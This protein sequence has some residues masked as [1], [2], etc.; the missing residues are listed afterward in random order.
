[1][2]NQEP[3]S[4]ATFA[5]GAD[6]LLSFEGQ[7]AARVD[8]FWIQQQAEKELARAG[9]WYWDEVS[10]GLQSITLTTSIP[11]VLSWQY[12][13]TGIP[14]GKATIWVSSEPDVFW[15]GDYGLPATDGTWRRVVAVGWNRSNVEASIRPLVRSFAPGSVQ[16]D[17][18][19]LRPAWLREGTVVNI[20][21]TR[22]RIIG[23]DD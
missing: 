21:E 6:V 1:M 20:D 8:G 23:G 12:R 4:A 22:F 7:L 9:F 17:D 15:P 18:V 11:Y 19:Q 5:G 16:F 3:F 14:D 10:Q 13:A 2:F